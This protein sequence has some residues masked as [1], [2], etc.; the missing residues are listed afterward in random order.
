M[1]K[2]N[3]V[4]RKFQ[5]WRDKNLTYP[6]HPYKLLG[7]KISAI[8]LIVGVI[9]ALIGAYISLTFGK[10]IFIIGSIIALAGFVVAFVVNLAPEEFINS[11]KDFLRTEKEKG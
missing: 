8:G 2:L 11:K 3:D 10:T 7:L 6:I 1:S 4:N 9:G 5:Q